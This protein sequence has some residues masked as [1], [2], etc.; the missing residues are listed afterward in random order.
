MVCRW[1]Q[2]LLVYHFTIIHKSNNMM[3]YVD[4][5]TWIF[6]YLICHHIDIAALLRFRD[7]AKRPHAYA[8]TKFGNV[9]NVKV[10]ETDNHSRKPP[11]LI[12]SDV[13]CCFYKDI[14][15]ELFHS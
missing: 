15:T 6:G 14:I 1:A 4:A 12:T 13:F 7:Q 2:E 10:T 8:A 9:D 3:V 11:L 5:L